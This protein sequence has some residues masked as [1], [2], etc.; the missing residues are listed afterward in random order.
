MWNFSIHIYTMH[1][2]WTHIW[3][4]MYEVYSIQ[5]W[6]VSFRFGVLYWNCFLFRFVVNFSNLIFRSDFTILLLFGI[7]TSL[8]THLG[9][10]SDF[11]FIEDF[12]FFFYYD[13]PELCELYKRKEKKELKKT[14]NEIMIHEDFSNSLAMGSI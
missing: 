14:E 9:V 2:R 8:L 11:P 6:F 5:H 13:Y 10:Y 4:F 12:I 1:K 3:A 7:I